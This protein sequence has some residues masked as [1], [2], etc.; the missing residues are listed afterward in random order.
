MT[1]TIRPLVAADMPAAARINRAAF[2]AF[3]GIPD[4]AKFRVDADVIGPRWRLEPNVSVALD[5][6]GKLA[7]TALTVRWGS[8][9]VVGPV[10]VAPEHWSRGFARQLMTR[11]MELVDR[12]APGLVGLVTHPQSPKHVRLYE[13]FGFRMQRITAVM[14]KA[15]AGGA[16]GGWTLLSRTGAGQPAAVAG[17]KALTHGIFPGLDVSTEALDMIKHNLGDT[18]ILGDPAT[19]EGVAICHHGVGSEASAGTVFVKFAASRG[20]EGA[21][22]RFR[23]LLAA[24]EGFAAQKGVAQIIGGNNTGRAEAYEL[25]Q[26]AGYRTMMNII[27]M[28][29]PSSDG[30]NRPGVFVVDDWR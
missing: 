19:P 25:M 7:G 29:R 18:V 4:P 8:V 3:F 16:G 28:M 6:E 12:S 11:L 1:V 20:G 10:T 9:C 15:V 21:P 17:M 5:F 26:G 2:S 22:E 23:R 14:S 30:Y 24:C 13:S 27:A